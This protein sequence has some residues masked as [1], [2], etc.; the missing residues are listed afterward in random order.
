MWTAEVLWIAAIDRLQSSLRI[1]TRSLVR[2]ALYVCST[3]PGPPQSG[4]VGTMHRVIVSIFASPHI[5]RDAHIRS[6][7]VLGLE[8]AQD[9][10]TPGLFFSAKLRLLDRFVIH[11]CWFRLALWRRCLSFLIIRILALL[12]NLVYFRLP[13]RPLAV[14]IPDL[15]GLDALLFVLATLL[16][17]C[18]QVLN[19][20]FGGGDPSGLCLLLAHSRLLD[21]LLLSL[22]V[23]LRR[24]DHRLELG[25]LCGLGRLLDRFGPSLL[26]C[27]LIHRQDLLRRRGRLD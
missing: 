3:D 19:L 13:V 26:G 15:T 2:K 12:A 7:G 4:D 25:G 24:R 1:H 23:R 11:L 10:Q 16:P 21:D 27:R 14:T 9:I 18:L 22:Q 5:I 20:G 6:V 17:A 8:R